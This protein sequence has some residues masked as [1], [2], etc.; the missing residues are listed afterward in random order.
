[1]AELR[2]NTWTLDQWYDQDVAGNVSYSGLKSFWAW[3][4]KNY[5]VLANNQSSGPAQTTPLEIPGTTWETLG[6][7]A[8][9]GSYGCAIKV[10]VH[11]GY[12]EL[13]LWVH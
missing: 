6:A 11:Y 4:D 5:G 2:Q 13:M 8:Q 3:G 7:D 1:M 12:G 9:A 10:M